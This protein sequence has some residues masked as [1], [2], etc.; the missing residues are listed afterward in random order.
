LSGNAV[1]FRSSSQRQGAEAI[2]RCTTARLAPRSARIPAVD[3]SVVALASDHDRFSRPFF[4][5]AT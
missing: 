2:N 3:Q 5:T 4:T 1:R